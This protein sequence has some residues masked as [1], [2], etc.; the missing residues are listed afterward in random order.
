MLRRGVQSM[1]DDLDMAEVLDT[2]I[3]HAYVDKF[4]TATHAGTKN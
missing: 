4:T 2:S 3:I 1:I